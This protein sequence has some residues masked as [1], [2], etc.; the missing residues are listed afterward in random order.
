MRSRVPLK[1]V[2]ASLL[3]PLVASVLLF[4]AAPAHAGGIQWLTNLWHK[5]TGTATAPVT[6]DD[7]SKAVLNDPKQ[8]LK[9][10]QAD[11]IKQELKIAAQ[12][13][14]PVEGK[15]LVPL[16]NHLNGVGQRKSLDAQVFSSYEF[17]DSLPNGRKAQI[18]VDFT[19]I[20][21]ILRLKI[22]KSSADQPLDYARQLL[23]MSAIAKDYIQSRSNSQNQMSALQQELIRLIY[24][25]RK[26]SAQIYAELLVNAN[27]GSLPS[28]ERLMQL[29]VALMKNFVLSGE[30]MDLLSSHL[31]ESNSVFEQTLRRHFSDEVARLESTELPELTRKA[32][33]DLRRRQK[34]L[35][36]WRQETRALEAYENQELKLNDLIVR[37]DRAGVKKMLEAYLPWAV[38]E[39]TEARA[40]KMWLDAIVSPDPSKQTVAFRGVDFRTDFVQQLL[41]PSTGQIRHGFMSTML[42]QNQGSYTRRLRSLSTKRI[43]NGDVTLRK[44]PKENPSVRITEQMH[45]HAQ[46]PQGSI[47]IS[48]TYDPYI[49]K[50]FIGKPMERTFKGEKT[51][52][53][54]GGLLA[55]KMDA[56]RLVPNL[57]SM[58]AN[59][60]ELLAPLIIFPDEI[61]EYKE[62]SKDD[63]NIKDFIRRV[64]DRTGLKFTEPSAMDNY[65]SSKEVSKELKGRYIIDGVSFN[66]AFI[67]ASVSG[68]SCQAVWR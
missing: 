58:Y 12:E 9:I 16:M 59:E 38:M 23:T 17:V 11:V 27:E 31:K 13:G 22:V 50:N 47:F 37:N 35:D 10:N 57:S 4:S 26:S 46:N 44:S 8:A 68:R 66:K 56:R 64:E 61:I 19:D 1:S 60:V 34:T 6:Q 14:L 63:V 7:V 15:L 62:M 5:I 24:S 18:D 52:V 29:E 3:A 53:P 36:R 45:S 21:M 2:P 51:V 42:T 40:W 55:V 67:G 65:I 49:A 32:T 43:Q 48:F 54:G 30:A 33:E 25:D 41:D 20:A 28:Q 39:P